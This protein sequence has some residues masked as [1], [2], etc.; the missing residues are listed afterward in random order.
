MNSVK[1]WDSKSAYK[2]QAA[3]LYTNHKLSEKEIKIVISCTIAPERIK[4]LK[5]NLT[6]AVKDLHVENY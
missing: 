5:A 6:K 1:L 3:L 2:K 4:Y